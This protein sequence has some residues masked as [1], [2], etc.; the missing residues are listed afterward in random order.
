V[1]NEERLRSALPVRGLGAELHFYR[2]LG[3]TNDEAGVLARRGAPEGTLI[4]AEEQTSGRGRAG[5]AWLTPPGSA[6]ALSILLRPRALAP[7]AVGSLSAL[8]ALAVAEALD[9]Q[10]ADA[11][12]KWPNDVL[13]DGRKVAG[14]LAEGSW[15]G[16]ALEHVVVGIGVNVKPASDPAEGGLAYPATCV[17][18]AVGRS[19]DRHALLVG[20]VEGMARWYPRLGTQPLVDAWER[21]LAFRGREVSIVDEEGNDTHR[22]MVEG[23][24]ADGRLKLRTRQGEVILLRPEGSHLRSV[25]TAAA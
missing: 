8:G 25:D 18:A 22:G 1:L 7:E 17:E 15:S 13:L 19:V 2:T 6:I 24:L 16:D 23:L 10:G 4:V 9:A 14:V 12:I 20:I 5:H 3:S 11:L 21:R